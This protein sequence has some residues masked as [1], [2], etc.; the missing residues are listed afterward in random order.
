V[1]KKEC[2]LF[3]F[4]YCYL[5]F[6]HLNLFAVMSFIK[7]YCKKAASVDENFFSFWHPVKCLII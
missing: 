7:Y 1:F 6:D 2:V 5:I 4:V 3:K